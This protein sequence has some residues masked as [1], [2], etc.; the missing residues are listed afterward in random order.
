MYRHAQKEEPMEVD[1]IQQKGEETKQLDQIQDNLQRLSKQ[2]D[3][4]SRQVRPAQNTLQGHS[5]RHP[6]NQYR[7]AA[8]ADPGNPGRTVPSRSAAAS[9]SETADTGLI[10]TTVRTWQRA[11]DGSAAASRHGISRRA[12]HMDVRWTTRLCPMWPHW[13]HRQNL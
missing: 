4:V 12:I 7:L 6:S 13:T 2:L 11:S 1:V 10:Q 5:P 8:A 3:R 9:L